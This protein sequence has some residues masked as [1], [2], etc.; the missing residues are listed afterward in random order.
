MERARFRC[1]IRRIEMVH[2][3]ADDQLYAL[4][5]RF[6]RLS[7]YQEI[8]VPVLV[9]GLE[10]MD[11]IWSVLIVIIGHRLHW[12]VLG[13]VKIENIGAIGGVAYAFVWMVVWIVIAELKLADLE[14]RV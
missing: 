9:C 4:S 11:A 6:F 1:V 8:I 2:I 13:L 3:L 10:A 5:E 7:G 14:V 12:D